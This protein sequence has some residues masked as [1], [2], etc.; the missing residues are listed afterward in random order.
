MLYKILGNYS[1]VVW[2]D[3]KDVTKV[4]HPSYPQFY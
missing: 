4:V 2:R 3:A 1:I